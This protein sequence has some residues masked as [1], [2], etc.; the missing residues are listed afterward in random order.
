MLVHVYE[1]N[2][3]TE[4]GGMVLNMSLVGVLKNQL[5]LGVMY[6]IAA[7]LKVIGALAVLPILRY[8][9]TKQV[10]MPQLHH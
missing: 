4:A 5:P 2:A 6:L 1:E 7:S 3:K 8:K 10:K 9:Q